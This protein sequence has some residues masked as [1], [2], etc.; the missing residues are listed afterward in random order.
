[1]L[2]GL[3]AR[4]DDASLFSKILNSAVFSRQRYHRTRSYI[5]MAPTEP[6]YKLTT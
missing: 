3:E 5:G 1:M 2:P 6:F 4:L